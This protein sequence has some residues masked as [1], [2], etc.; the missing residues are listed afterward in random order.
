MKNTQADIYLFCQKA[1]VI[2]DF[3]TTKGICPVNQ[4]PLSLIQNHLVIENRI[5]RYH[6]VTDY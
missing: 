5:K 1:T 4:V 3:S 2:G 6:K